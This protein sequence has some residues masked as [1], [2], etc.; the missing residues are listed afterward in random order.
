MQTLRAFERP[1]QVFLAQAVSAL[2]IPTVGVGL[3]AMWDVA[4]ALLAYLAYQTVMA[5]I[6]MFLWIIINKQEGTLSPEAGAGG[7]DKIETAIY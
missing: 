1:N 7:Q 4:G 2:V 5:G 3:M 6:L